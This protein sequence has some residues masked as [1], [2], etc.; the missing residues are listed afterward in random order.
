MGT[1]RKVLK[2]KGSKSKKT[3]EPEEEK[4]DEV[5]YK[6]L[7]HEIEFQ[8]RKLSYCYSAFVTSKELAEHVHDDRVNVRLSK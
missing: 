7:D 2:L 8:K 5:Q 3:L 4:D 6:C 1:V